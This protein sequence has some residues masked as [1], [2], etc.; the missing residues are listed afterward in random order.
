MYR[1][2]NCG[3]VFEEA[4][5]MNTTYE[6]YYGVS[7]DFPDRTPLTLEVCPSCESDQIDEIDEMDE[8]LED[9]EEE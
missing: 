6:S 3:E 2:L 8:F 7:S 1:C 4:D 9:E 5:E